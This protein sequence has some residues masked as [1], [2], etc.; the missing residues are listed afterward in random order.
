M[1]QQRIGREPRFRS[2]SDAIGNRLDTIAAFGPEFGH[3]GHVTYA[4][5]HR[6]QELQPFPEIGR[7]QERGSMAQRARPVRARCRVENGIDRGAGI[8]ILPS[9]EP[10]QRPATREND[11]SLRDEA[12]GFKQDLR[13]AGRHHAGQGPTRDRK[14][15]LERACGENDPF[16]AYKTRRAAD[17]NAQFALTRQTPHHRPR[18]I[19]RAACLE[20]VDERGAAPIIVAENRVAFGRRVGNRAVNLA[21]RRGLLVEQHATQ[22]RAGANGCR[23][24]TGGT[25]ADD[26]DVILIVER[27][28]GAGFAWVS[29]RMPSRTRTRQ[30]CRLGLPSIVTRH[31][32]QTPIMQ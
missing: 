3:A 25:G 15:P 30:P 28:H 31:S 20:F 19:G 14:R 9:N 10:E 32:K 8:Q 13:G 1:Q 29:I 7:C 6:A 24:E 22:A 5:S 18:D 11:T 26:D 16:R 2:A 4:L 23:G 27:A 21:A 17:R 12:G